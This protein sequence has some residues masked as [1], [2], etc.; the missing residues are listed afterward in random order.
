MFRKV[1]PELLQPFGIDLAD[2]GNHVANFGHRI[3]EIAQ[4]LDDPFV[5][6]LHALA[7]NQITHPFKISAP[8]FVQLV[9]QPEIIL[10]LVKDNKL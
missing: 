3:F 2:K 4:I 9:A 7:S 10:D 1:L 6:I 8:G 5:E